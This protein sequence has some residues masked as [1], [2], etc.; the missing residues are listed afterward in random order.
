L[1]KG[2]GLAYVPLDRTRGEV[3]TLW[4]IVLLQARRTEPFLQRVRLAAMTE[5]I[6]IPHAPQ[7]GYFVESCAARRS[8]LDQGGAT[9]LLRAY[10]I[11][12]PR[13]SC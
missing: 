4:L 9:P 12:C 3:E 11:D 7:R 1:V 10:A 2:S 6:A 13:C 5:S 8:Y